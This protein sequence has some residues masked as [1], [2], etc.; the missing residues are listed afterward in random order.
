MTAVLELGPQARE[1]AVAEL[2]ARI[3]ALPLPSANDEA[4]RRDN[5]FLFT[6]LAYLG[7]DQDYEQARQTMVDA[8]YQPCWEQARPLV[9]ASQQK[10][11]GLFLLH[12]F[13]VRLHKDADISD[14][15]TAW[16]VFRMGELRDKRAINSLFK[17]LESRRWAWDYASRKSLAKIG[18]A[19]VETRALALLTSDDKD[20]ARAEAVKLLDA[21][22]GPKMLPLLRRMIRESDFGSKSDALLLMARYGTPDDLTTLVPLADFWTG[23]RGLHYWAKNAVAEIRRRYDYDIQGPIKVH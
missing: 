10:D 18:G 2:L 3:K 13:D 4:I 1:K 22:Q 9:G 11:E 14:D 16:A 17:Y 19:E 21:L 7:N 12:I 20:W 15:V 6:E 5:R 23:D 8:E